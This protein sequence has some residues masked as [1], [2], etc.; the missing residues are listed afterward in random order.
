ML[1]CLPS[2]YEE[3]KGEPREEDPKDES[4]M[5]CVK[6]VKERAPVASVDLT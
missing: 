4:H 2:K 5:S 3:G 1:K 6:F